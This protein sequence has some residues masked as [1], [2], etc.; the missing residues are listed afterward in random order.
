MRFEDWSYLWPPRPSKAVSKSLLS[1]Y[2]ADG[3]IAQAKMNGTC[4]VLAVA[5][6]RNSVRTMSRHNSEHKLWSPSAHTVAPFKKLP[7]DGWYV[8]IA[9]LMHS[10]VPGI[11]DINYIHDIVVADGKQL[12]GSTFAERQALL[13][14]LFGNPVVT[15]E[16]PITHFV[17]DDH[18]WL[19]RN[20]T[21]GFPNL[22]ERMHDKPESE[23]LVLKNPKGR[24]EMCAKQSSNQQWQVKCRKPHVNYG[25]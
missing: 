11:R 20:F 3:W 13:H 25:Y 18:T 8:F 16:T 24:L 12:V 21:R 2:S 15:P 4:N 23:G 19:A 6:D 7:G 9:E 10:K 14:D 22:F 1:G 5:P 17:L